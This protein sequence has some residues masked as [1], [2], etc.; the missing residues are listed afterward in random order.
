MRAKIFRGFS[1]IEIMIVLLIVA[2]IAAASAPMV[3]KKLAGRNAGIGDSP[4]VF[5]G[6][7]SNIAYNLTG[8]MGNLSPNSI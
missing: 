4:W 6:L 7:N 1:L 3:T 2:V 5:T 8:L